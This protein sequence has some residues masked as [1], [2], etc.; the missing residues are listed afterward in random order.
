MA[1]F[2][3]AAAE[4]RTTKDTEYHE[5][6]LTYFLREPSEPLWSMIRKLYH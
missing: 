2:Q 4:P 1:Q 3:A 5:G 6:M